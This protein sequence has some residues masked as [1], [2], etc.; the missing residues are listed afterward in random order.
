MNLNLHSTTDGASERYLTSMIVLIPLGSVLLV[1]LLVSYIFI[2]H[3]Q[4]FLQLEEQVVA[5]TIL[6]QSRADIQREVNRMIGHLSITHREADQRLRAGLEQHALSRRDALLKLYKDWQAQLSVAERVRLLASSV[7]SPTSG[8]LNNRTILYQLMEDGDQLVPLNS[9][10]LTPGLSLNKLNR[11]L[12][13]ADSGF[14]LAPEFLSTADGSD[15]DA[16]LYVAPL[17]ETGLVLVELA[18]LARHEA[19]LK[20]QLLSR[21][22][23][24]RYG[25][26]GYLFVY[27]AAGTYIMNPFMPQLAGRTINSIDD[28]EGN[29]IWEEFQ[30]AARLPGGSFVNYRWQRPGNTEIE[31][32]ITFARPYPRW[33]WVIASGIYVEDAIAAAQGEQRALSERVD[34]TIRRTIVVVGVV[35]ALTFVITLLV[36]RHISDLLERYQQ[37]LRAKNDELNAWNERLELGIAERTRELEQKNV[38]LDRLS[39]TDPLTGLSN[40][41]RL[42]EFFERVI[43]SARRYR[44]PFSVVLMDLDRFKRINDTWGHPVGDDVLVKVGQLLLRNVRD[45][46]IVGRWGGEEF[47][48]ILPETSRDNALIV[49]ESL[50]QHIVA[51]DVEPVEQVTSSFGVTGFCEGDTIERMMTRAD[52]AL[53]EAKAEGRNRVEV[54]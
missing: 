20:Q 12:G 6:D 13:D 3:Q 34:S 53:Y 16:L 8:K 38:E 25:D 36:A 10:S 41:L 37:Q 5:S 39:S 19:E 54:M 26:D 47:L 23:D 32:K 30:Q 45:A 15:S 22:K 51:L 9:G 42:D 14:V 1:A 7:A 4:A 35:L 48:L 29:P 18:S 49:A 28:A 24:Y 50:R 21:I 2:R 46:D 27:S 43:S 17:E 31:D 33:G 44:R 11:Q 52:K 40:R